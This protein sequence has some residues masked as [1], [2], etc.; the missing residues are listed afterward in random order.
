MIRP[1]LDGF[2]R[3]EWDRDGTVWDAFRRSCPPNSPSRRLIETVRSAESGGASALVVQG[4]AT[5]KLDAPS[6]R[7]K[8]SGAQYPPTRELSF[9]S[10]LDAE[11]DICANPSMH[12]LH[13]AFFS[14][15]RSIEYL[16]PVFSP[17]KPP[18][19]ADI[20]IPSHHYWSPSSEFTYEWEMTRGRTKEPTDLDWEVKKASAYWRGKVTRGADTPPGRAPSFQKQ[21][22]VKM[23]NEA[24][25]GAKRVLV[26][27]DDK[28]AG[29]TSTSA[30]VAEVNKA[31]LDV[32]MACDPNLGECSYLR[33]LGYRVEPP[34]PLSEAWK[35]KYV[36]DIDEIGFSPR[37]FALMES[38]SAVVKSSV[39]R[40]FWSDWVMPWCA[41]PPPPPLLTPSSR[42]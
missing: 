6:T 9:N 35:H 28:T 24:I 32:A 36:L 20:L 22:L 26:A 40:E 15:Q 39:Q 19:F 3:T 12:P 37:F 30:G 17:S 33:S 25:A 41:L 31:A 4:R 11:T 23:A 5:S 21:R 29:L 34:G 13:S 1:T 27:F 38:K 18:G 16:Y 8:T 2:N 42:R 10:D 14:D 7:R